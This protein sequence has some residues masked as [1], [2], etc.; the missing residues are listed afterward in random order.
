MLAVGVASAALAITLAVA[1]D[2]EADIV[3]GEFSLALNGTQI[4]GGFALNVSVDHDG[5]LGNYQAAQWRIDYPEDVVS[6]AS[7][8]KAP[9]APSDCGLAAPSDDGDRV[10]VGCINFGGDNISYSGAAF[11]LQFTCVVPGTADFLLTNLNL[12]TFVQTT[13]GFQPIHIHD[14]TAEC[15]QPPTETPTPT[16]TLTPTHSPTPTITLTHTPT[17]LFSPTPTATTVPPGGEYLTRV[18][19]PTSQPLSADF[20]KAVDDDVEQQ[21]APGMRIADASAPNLG[22]LRLLYGLQTGGGPPVQ[23]TVS[24]DVNNDGV[25]TFPDV[26]IVLDAFGEF[27]PEWPGN[28]R[29][30]VFNESSYPSLT[31]LTNAIDIAVEAEIATGWDPKGAASLTLDGSPKYVLALERRLHQ[32]RP[33]D[34]DMNLD[35]RITFVDVLEVLDRFGLPD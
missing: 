1:R 7:M 27:V 17:P 21:I 19:D 31:D 22:G 2:S 5:G 9:A 29:H 34:G 12:D 24:G 10:L 18:Y 26:L 6:V 11:I 14:F 3:P 15:P 4:P 13:T 35:G 25:V 16:H 32:N 33:A 23:I 8:V 28:A 30:L 20:L